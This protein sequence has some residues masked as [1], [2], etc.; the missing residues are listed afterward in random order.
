MPSDS[1]HCVLCLRATPD[2]RLAIPLASSQ[3]LRPAGSRPGSGKR[4]RPAVSLGVS[5]LVD[6]RALL[7]KRVLLSTSLFDEQLL[8][9]ECAAYAQQTAHFVLCTCLLHCPMSVAVA[10]SSLRY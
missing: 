9:V 10:A 4:L 6:C 8:H 1:V 5:L 3:A 2:M 7:H